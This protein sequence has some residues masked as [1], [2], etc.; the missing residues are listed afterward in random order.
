MNSASHSSHAMRERTGFEALAI[1]AAHH[2]DIRALRAQAGRDRI[3]DAA[4]FIRRVVEHLDLMRAKRPLHRRC[5]ADD[6]LGD[7]GLIIERELRYHG[8]AVA[9]FDRE[10]FPTLGEQSPPLPLRALAG[11]QTPCKQHVAIRHVGDEQERGDEM[12]AAGQRADDGSKV[13]EPS[14]SE[15]AARRFIPAFP[16]KPLAERLRAPAPR[17]DVGAVALGP[18]RKGEFAFLQ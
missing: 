12:K 1:R 9:A 18:R 10:D 15:R 3:H 13:R 17:D 2:H 16:S 5:R 14:S 8:R 11:P 7:R 6:A 4:R